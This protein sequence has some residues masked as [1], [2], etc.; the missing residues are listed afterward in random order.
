MP[1]PAWSAR[2]VQVPVAT[3]AIVAPFVPPDVHTVGVVV[4]NVTVRP[5]DAVAPTTI[6]DC[7]NVTFAK[8]PNVI[9]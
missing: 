8:A 7:A 3:S 6:G 1:L 2:T 5:D 9:V 4:E